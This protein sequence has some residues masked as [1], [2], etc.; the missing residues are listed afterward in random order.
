MAFMNIESGP[1]FDYDDLFTA[2]KQMANLEEMVSEHTRLLDAARA[3]FK[4]QCLVTREYW[5]NDKQPSMEYLKQVI[6]YVGN[7]EADRD[8]LELREKELQKL[9]KALIEAKGRL[10]AMHEQIRIWQSA[11]A[12]ARK[13]LIE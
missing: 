13:T 5:H 9:Q 7:T 6:H 12:N 3:L 1:G 4:Q 2:W 10:D 11:G 8:Y